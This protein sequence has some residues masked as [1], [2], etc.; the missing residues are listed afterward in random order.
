MIRF[1]YA[2]IFLVASVAVRWLWGPDN[3]VGWLPLSAVCLVISASLFL[4]LRWSEHALFGIAIYVAVSWLSLVVV[5]VIQGFPY[6]DLLS[7]TVSLIP[8][9]LWSG[10]WVGMWFL[11]RANFTQGTP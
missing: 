9:L 6:H 2:A 7:S 1:A 3:L 8:G 10:F 5:A 4:R 11:V